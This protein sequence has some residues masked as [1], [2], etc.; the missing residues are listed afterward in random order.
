MEVTKRLTSAEVTEYR[1]HSQGLFDHLTRRRYA[2]LCDSHEVLERENGRLKR[3]VDAP[4]LSLQVISDQETLIADLTAQLADREYRLAQAEEQL[5][6]VGPSDA[7]WD[8]HALECGNCSIRIISKGGS[9]NDRALSD[10][11]DSEDE[12]LCGMCAGE[13]MYSLSDQLARRKNRQKAG[14]DWAVAT[15]GP[16]TIESTMRRI[17]QELREFYE[18]PA[19]EAKDI[20][21][22][23][24]RLASVAGFDL[25][26]DVD[27]KMEINR[28]RTWVLSGD[29]CG[30]HTGSTAKK[31]VMEELLE[32][33]AQLAERDKAIAGLMP[34]A[35]FGDQCM[36]DDYEGAFIAFSVHKLAL[37]RAESAEKAIAEAPHTIG[38]WGGTIA[39]GGTDENPN[40]HKCIPKCWKL[41][42]IA[43]IPA[44]SAAG[45][46]KDAAG[47][48]PDG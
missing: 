9:T 30:Q 28:A 3:I 39:A 44:L 1:V 26:E 37:A 25:D 41:R 45:A 4:D 33:R 31:G 46:E 38:C 43:A 47:E 12:A 29:G 10:P 2:A 27:R 11:G 20:A 42:A 7:Y 23:L 32:L 36:Q 48:I 14:Y 19:G 16:A 15:F 21:I 17:D 35:L 6:E 40:R 22:F 8:E 13:D 34:R 24:Y 5:A 18:D